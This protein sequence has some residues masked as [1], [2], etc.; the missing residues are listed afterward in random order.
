M[1]RVDA[2]GGVKGF[3]VLLDCCDHHSSFVRSALSDILT[4]HR[5]CT[6]LH[7]PSKHPCTAAHGHGRRH[8]GDACHPTAHFPT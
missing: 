7:A 6:T 2:Y 3:G 1:S 4:L 5:A 8:D